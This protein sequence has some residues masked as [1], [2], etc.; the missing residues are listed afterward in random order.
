MA[1]MIITSAFETLK[2]EFESKNKPLVLDEFVL[3]NVPEQDENAAIDRAE[4]LPPE[5]QIVFTGAVTQSGF[6]SPNA[7]IYSL[8]MD[9]G[10]G[11]FSFNWIGLRNK[12]QGTLAAISHIP[13]LNKIKS[14][15][16]VK[17]GNA[18]TRSLMM[19]YV[20]AKAATGITVDASTWQIDFTARLMCID[21]TERLSN[22]DIYEHATFIS[23]G[24]QVFKEGNSYK[25][26]AGIGY[27]GGLRCHATAEPVISNVA[28]NRSIYIDASWQGGLTSQWQTFVQIIASENVL[29]DYVDDTGLMHYVTK[30]AEIDNEGNVIDCRVTGGIPALNARQIKTTGA[31][32][33]GGLLSAGL[34]LSVENATTKQVG[35]VQ[36]EDSTTSTSISKAATPNAV[37]LA[38]ERGE[39]AETN[40]KAHSDAGIAKLLGGAPIAALDT[41]IELGNALQENDSD[42][43]AINAVIATK[44]SASELTAHASNKSNPHGVT[45]A[46]LGLQHVNNWPATSATDDPSTVKYGTAAGVKAAKDHA[47]HALN[48]ANS[49]IRVV[50][51]VV[52]GS[53]IYAAGYDVYS[54]GRI[55]QWGVGVYDCN[56][57][58]GGI[59]TYLI[60]FPNES[61]SP[62]ACIGDNTAGPLAFAVIAS[63]VA[64]TGFGFQQSHGAGQIRV[65]YQVWGS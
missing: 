61:G 53:G 54:D 36:L 15:P 5:N 46:Q 51:R 24:Y 30:I 16:G 14:V 6:V 39:L 4:S 3:A 22:L 52:V 32:K 13:L 44:A 18:V 31:L 7:V 17:N 63:Q 8:I 34:I 47:I 56:S 27:V 25:T 37:R 40:A 33:G 48:T 35:V 42:I 23:E 28:N 62:V 43:A 2:A 21:E 9:T 11:D 65:N 45:K 1:Q 26:K 38:F 58:G 60:Q 59:I 19:S 55:F 49:I 12:V 10:I 20:G 29:T 41:I 57:A 50:K 64:T